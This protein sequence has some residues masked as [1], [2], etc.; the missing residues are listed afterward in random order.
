MTGDVRHSAAARGR[1]ALVVLLVVAG[2]LGA[3]AR[4]GNLSGP[5]VRVADG[6]TLTVRVGQHTDKVRLYG[7]DCPERHQ[8]F[9]ARAKRTTAELT[10]GGPVRVEVVGRD[11]YGRLLGK[12]F[13]ADGRS[14]NQEL[15][16]RGLAWWYRLYSN[17]A[18]L[19]ALEAEARTARRGLWVD[20]HPIPPWEFRRRQRASQTDR[21]R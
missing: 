7:I 15:V 4:G 20:P 21:G 16:R 8:A 6:D 9:G 10:A 12:V 11:D 5:V 17:D 18:T 14:L 19:A 3:P 1:G 2:C 13:L